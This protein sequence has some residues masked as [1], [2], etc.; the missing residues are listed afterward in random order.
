MWKD[1]FSYFLQKE[2]I[3]LPGKEDGNPVIPLVVDVV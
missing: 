1:M 3:I 2:Q